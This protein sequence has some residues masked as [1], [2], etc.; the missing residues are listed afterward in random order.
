MKPN[1]EPQ[2]ETTPDGDS[3]ERSSMALLLRDGTGAIRGDVERQVREAFAAQGLTPERLGEA[4]FE[5]EVRAEVQRLE[6]RG[7]SALRPVRSVLT[8]QTIPRRTQAT[9]PTESR[10]FE[11]QDWTCEWCRDHQWVKGPLGVVPCQ[12]CVPMETRLAWF[13]VPA[14]FRAL[15]LHQMQWLPGRGAA[16]DYVGKWDG[17]SVVLHSAP[18]TLDSLWGTG[19][20]QI[21]VLLMRRQINRGAA[22]R[23]LP[24]VD[25]FERLRA[26]FSDDSTEQTGALLERFASE[27]LLVIDDLGAERPTDWTREQV[28]TLI[29]K[30]DSAQRATIITTNATGFEELAGWVGGAVASRLRNATWIAVGGADLRGAK[31]DAR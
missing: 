24:A 31:G 14:R 7:S 1:D 20:T 2:Q 26:T 10:P 21:A 5:V 22:A 30:R 27:P 4:E 23:F 8:T 11:D 16:L 28:R 9:E 3:P 25:L 13:G 29:D 18:G 17:E 15:E 6:L 19:K 12:R